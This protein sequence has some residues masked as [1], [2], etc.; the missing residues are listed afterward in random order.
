MVP[1]INEFMGRHNLRGLDTIDQLEETAKGL[2]GKQIV[3]D[4]LTQE[5]VEITRTSLL[6]RMI[7]A[8]TS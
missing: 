2:S 4:M 6:S 7:E 8:Y 3:C 1:Y 5:T